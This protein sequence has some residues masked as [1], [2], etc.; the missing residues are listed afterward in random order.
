[1]VAKT[2]KNNEELSQPY[3]YYSNLY[4]YSNF[5]ENLDKIVVLNRR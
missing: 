4:E 3:I 1:M 2:Y 5:Y